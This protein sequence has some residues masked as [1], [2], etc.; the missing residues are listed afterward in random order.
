[1]NEFCQ[2]LLQIAFRYSLRRLL[3][4]IQL[5]QLNMT[6][7]SNELT[8]GTHFVYRCRFFFIS[9]CRFSALFFSFL[10]FQLDDA[11]FTLRLVLGLKQYLHKFHGRMRIVIH[12]RIYVFASNHN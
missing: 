10:V 9:V 7:P 1:M 5:Q 11:L 4:T 2:R 8:T 3:G 12:F 6:I